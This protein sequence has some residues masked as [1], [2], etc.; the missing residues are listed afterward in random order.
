MLEQLHHLFLQEDNVKAC[1]PE[2][3][4]QEEYDQKDRQLTDLLLIE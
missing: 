4:S 1:L 3:Y 2:T